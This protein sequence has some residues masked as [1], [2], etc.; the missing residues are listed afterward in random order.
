[1][2]FWIPARDTEFAIRK[3]EIRCIERISIRKDGR[4]DERAVLFR[5]SF[6]PN[7]RERKVLGLQKYEPQQA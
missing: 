4:T 3:L 6:V 5:E 1:M 2:R 7:W